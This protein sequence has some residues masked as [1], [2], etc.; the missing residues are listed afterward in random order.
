MPKKYAEAARRQLGGLRELST[1]R[2][3]GMTTPVSFDHGWHGLE[4]D[5]TDARARFPGRQGFGRDEFSRGLGTVARLMCRG[6]V[7]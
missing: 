7:T 4:T 5:G 3:G 2:E 1:V 6:R